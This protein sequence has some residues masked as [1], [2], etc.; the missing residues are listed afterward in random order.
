MSSPQDEMFRQIMGVHQ[1][2][3]DSYLEEWPR[4]PLALAGHSVGRVHKTEEGD[5]ATNSNVRDALW[6]LRFLNE[7]TPAQNVHL[8]W[9]PLGLT[10]NNVQGSVLI[11]SQPAHGNLVP[12]L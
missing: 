1:G 6:L 10:V 4:E 3:V 11:N 7:E 2:T 9:F 12:C 5:L 8:L